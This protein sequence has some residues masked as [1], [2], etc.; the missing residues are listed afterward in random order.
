V[1]NLVFDLAARVIACADRDHPADA[2]LRET[3][4]DAG[5]LSPQS[6]RA[7]SRAVFSYYRWLGWLNKVRGANARIARALDFAERFEENPFTLPEQPLRAKAVPEWTAQEVDVTVPWLRSLQREPHVWLRAR[8]GKGRDLGRKLRHTKLASLPDAL[9]YTGL[10]DLFQTAEFQ[11]GEFEL[12]DLSSQAVGFV[13]APKPGETWW[14][15]CAGEGGKLLHLS[16]LMENRGLIWASD[17]AEW[18]LKRLQRRTARAQVFNYRAETWDGSAR[19]PTKTVFDGVLVDAPCSGVGTWQRNP[20]ARWTTTLEDVRELAAVQKQ[21][22]ANV[23]LAVKPGG[24]LV[25]AVCT[26]AKAETL[27]VVEDFARRFPNFTPLPILNPLV[28]E[29]KAPTPSARPESDSGAIPDSTS[30]EPGPARGEQAVAAPRALWLWPQMFG[31][32][33][34]FLA[35]WRRE[36]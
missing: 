33:G 25:Y 2:V 1:D 31:C 16:D 23:A 4:H 12:Q 28:T 20:H 17:R 14:D 11:A 15:A 3:L 36:T 8:K 10:A 9:R 22:L 13:C 5:T 21:L 32:N 24:K 19:L 34:M 7:V 26:L 18:R 29:Q 6:S 30:A 27:G 35:Q